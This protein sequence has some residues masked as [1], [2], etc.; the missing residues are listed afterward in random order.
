MDTILGVV[1]LTIVY[2]ATTHR[3]CLWSLFLKL[4]QKT[5]QMKVILSQIFSSCGR[6]IQGLLKDGQESSS[7]ISKLFSVSQYIR[8]ICNCVVQQ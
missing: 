6:T 7:I 1:W 4:K 3:R 2:R 8:V 5:I